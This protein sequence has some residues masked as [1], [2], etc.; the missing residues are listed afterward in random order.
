[1]RQ[2]QYIMIHHSLTKDTQTVS[3][4]AIRRYHVDILGW[5]DIGYHFGVERV[6]DEF[7]ILEGRPLSENGAHCKQHN[8]NAKAIGICCIG[9]FDEY[10]PPTGQML[11]LRTLCVDLCKKFSLLPSENIVMHRQ[12]A[13]YKTCPG[14]LFPF[15]EFVNSLQDEIFHIED[16]K[17]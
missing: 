15:Q 9:N 5:N 8:M 14:K 1:M 4:N 11:A 16:T 3:W 10:P 12:F 6:G 7:Q 13:P 17:I 2:W